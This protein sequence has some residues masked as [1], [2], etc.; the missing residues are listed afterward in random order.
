MT[1]IRPIQC[2][3]QALPVDAT[4]LDQVKDDNAQAVVG[5]DR[6]LVLSERKRAG[7][8]EGNGQFGNIRYTS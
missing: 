7:L 3:A 6:T 2:E 1:S 8:I 5:D 4:G